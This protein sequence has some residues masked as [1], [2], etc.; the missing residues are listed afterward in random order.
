MRIE[1]TSIR[2]E[3]RIVL[4]SA[5]MSERPIAWTILQRGHDIVASDGTKVGTVKEVVADLDKDI[6][7]GITYSPGLTQPD[8]FVPA[9]SIAEITDQEVLLTVDREGAAALEPYEG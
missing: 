8:L 2:K 3:R 9:E 1:H 7:S 4:V 6:F 5:A